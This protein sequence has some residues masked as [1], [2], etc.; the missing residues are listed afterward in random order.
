MAQQVT[1]IPMPED[2]ARQLQANA[3]KAG[4]SLPTYIALLARVDVRKHDPAFVSAA[5]YLFK[6][7]PQSLKRLSE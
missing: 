7:F 6:K 2:L 3:A 5:Q 1:N 4:L